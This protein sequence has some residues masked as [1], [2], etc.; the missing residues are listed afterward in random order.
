M[1]KMDRILSDGPVKI[2]FILYIDVKTTDRRHYNGQFLGK[3]YR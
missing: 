1:N 3:A 2:L